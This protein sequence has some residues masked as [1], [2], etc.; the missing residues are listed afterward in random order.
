M[1]SK[2][3]RSG[4]LASAVDY[5]CL[6]CECRLHNEDIA[7]A[8]INKPVHTKKFASTEYFENKDNYVRKIQKWYFCEVCN[9]LLFTAA[10]V[11]LHLNEPMHIYNKASNDLQRRGNSVVAFSSVQINEN[12]WNGLSG[13]TCAVCNVEFENQNIH[14][15]E[16]NHIIKLIQSKVE[17][18]SN[19][20]IS[21]K[22]D[23]NF[24][25]C[26]TCNEVIGLSSID[27]HFNS[28]DHKEQYQ[29][30]CDLFEICTRP[31][32]FGKTSGD[33]TTDKE[34]S[35][36]IQNLPENLSE[37]VNTS[38][39][40]MDI[41]EDKNTD[42]NI[43]EP[44][45][46]SPIINDKEICEILG[47]KNDYITIDEN[48]KSW[49]ILCNWVMDPFAVTGHI[50]NRHHRKILQLHE[51]RLLKLNSNHNSSEVTTP[52]QDSH[53]KSTEVPLPQQ[54]SNNKSPEKTENSNSNVH[55]TEAKTA[56]DTDLC[57]NKQDVLNKKNISDCIE[58]FQKNHININFENQSAVCKKCSKDLCFDVQ[59]I[60]DH[61]NEHA[62]KDAGKNI[63]S[64]CLTSGLEVTNSDE[65]ENK[66]NSLFTKPVLKKDEEVEIISKEDTSVEILSE[67]D[68]EE[69]LK[70]YMEQNYLVRGS[71]KNKVYCKK[72]NSTISYSKRN[73]KVHIEGAG[74]KKKMKDQD[75][76][77]V[78]IKAIQS[79]KTNLIKIP[80]N[81]FIQNVVTANGSQ[82]VVVINEEICLSIFSFMLITKLPNKMKCQ[83][84]NNYIY[85]DQWQLHIESNEHERQI[86][87][88]LVVVSKDL[89]DEFIREIQP[90]SF[91]CGYCNILKCS[92]KAMES[93]L[94]TTAHRENK[95]ALC[96]HLQLLKPQI[97]IHRAQKEARDH[98]MMR[99]FF[100]R[101]FGN[102]F[103]RDNDSDSD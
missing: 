46:D 92:W 95:T 35:K 79:D 6:V 23:D 14:V 22:I 15:N 9:L 78:P 89:K 68:T 94:E 41:Q 36:E 49:C 82:K 26:L 62:N 63:K 45:V 18:D 16:S 13:D 25:H 57:S 83:L 70:D 47:A 27:S 100:S 19:K 69:Q 3:S 96:W 53:K 5:F 55:S 7:N 56:V 101:M 97:L 48:G 99:M 64:I 8:H 2:L 31:K 37:G 102:W 43:K 72:C 38:D 90:N 30:C 91:H 33:S 39:V 32:A 4:V 54:D 42:D 87:E 80:T 58:N 44:S 11:R 77:L 28:T 67:S 73:I 1:I 29:N 98:F 75:K 93:H 84:C 61:I 21:R 50:N 86:D 17:I 66:K 10:R 20:N 59:A 12:S 65:I 103:N 40:D 24:I 52:K 74:H 71:N 81:R 88:C 51:N 85:R 76:Q 34:N 60:E